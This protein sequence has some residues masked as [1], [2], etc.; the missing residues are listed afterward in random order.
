MMIRPFGRRNGVS[1]D[2]I[3][4]YARATGI[5]I[6]GPTR[7]LS[8][9][10]P[11]VL[12]ERVL[13]GTPMSKKRF[14]ATRAPYSTVRYFWHSQGAYTRI[15]AIPLLIDSRK[16]GGSISSKSDTSPPLVPVCVSQQEWMMYLWLYLSAV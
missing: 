6:R 1:H 3:I 12:Y 2:T 13:Y 11:L 9:P 5:R 4:V 10:F 15:H 7:I 14:W 8:C 16:S